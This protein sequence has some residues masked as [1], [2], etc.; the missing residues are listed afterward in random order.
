M[1]LASITHNET[2]AMAS[3]EKEIELKK[4]DGKLSIGAN[5]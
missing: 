3:R 4:Y 5:N 2:S 1:V